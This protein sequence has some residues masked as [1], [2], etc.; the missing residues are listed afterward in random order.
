MKSFPK[1]SQIFQIFQFPVYLCI[2]N[3]TETTIFYRFLARASKKEGKNCDFPIFK[4]ILVRSMFNTPT[5]HIKLCIN[6]WWCECA[7]TDSDG[8]FPEC[9]RLLKTT[10]RLLLKI[11][12]D[13]LLRKLRRLVS[14]SATQG[15]LI[16]SSV[17]A[18]REK[19]QIV[20][21]RRFS[22]MVR[23][24][25]AITGMTCTSCSGCSWEIFCHCV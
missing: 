20:T 6:F 7:T 5:A 1:F 23:M 24:V 4:N 19:K 13:Q 11:I 21:H 2:S 14:V 12:H 16:D 8:K 3:S 10:S 18:K 9:R 15:S 25:L 17:F 22:K